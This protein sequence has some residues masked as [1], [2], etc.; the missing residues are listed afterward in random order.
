VIETITLQDL[1]GFDV[2]EG[3]MSAMSTPAM[4]GVKLS[5]GAMNNDQVDAQSQ[6]CDRRGCACPCEWASLC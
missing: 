3:L 2:T 5:R 1:P 4:Y 6:Q